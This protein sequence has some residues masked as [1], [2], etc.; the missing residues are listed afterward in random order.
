MLNQVVKKTTLKFFKIRCTC[1]IPSHFSYMLLVLSVQ[2]AA[3]RLIGLIIKNIEK[4]NAWFYRPRETAF[5]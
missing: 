1:A 5:K 3:N 2:I 4:I